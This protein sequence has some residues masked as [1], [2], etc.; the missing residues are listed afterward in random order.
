MPT[1][2]KRV[3]ED[4]LRAHLDEAIA[5]RLANGSAEQW[6][7]SDYEVAAIQEELYERRQVRSVGR[8]GAERPILRART[9]ALAR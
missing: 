4:G 8:H 1:S 3:D 5:E 6:I 9:Y 7:Y 2:W